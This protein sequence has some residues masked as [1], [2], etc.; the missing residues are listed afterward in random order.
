MP[1]PWTPDERSPLNIVDVG[2]RSTHYYVLADTAPRLILDA[3]W[4]GTIG[5]MQHMCSVKGVPLSTIPYQLATHYHIDH[6]GLVQDM[7]NLGVR[8]IV[9]NTQVAAIPLMR[10][11]IKPQDNYTEIELE[12]NIVIT[13]DESRAFLS[14][15]GI[16]G[17]IITTPGHSDDSVTLIVDGIGAFTGDL[18][19]LMAVPDNP[20]DLAYQ[21]WQKIRSK[22]VTTVYPA[23]TPPFQ[24]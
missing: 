20:A 3:G 5:M 16:R 17:E 24:L 6:A 19:P 7:K 4:P 14:T 1:R 9:L 11:H 13:E 21:S 15:I 8:L 10:R 12:G 22:G 2:Y 23:H 18:T